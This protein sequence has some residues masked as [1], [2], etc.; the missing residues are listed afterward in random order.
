M[1]AR[2]VVLGAGAA[3]LSAA[4][5]LAGIQPEGTEIIVVDRAGEHAF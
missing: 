4:N 1:N 2:V 5:R 3:G